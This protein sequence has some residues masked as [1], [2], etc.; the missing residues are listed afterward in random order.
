MRK[1]LQGKLKSLTE[2]VT[3]L[4]SFLIN[5]ILYRKLPASDVKKI[6]I[7]K[8]DHIG[9]V[10]L[11]TPVI[12]NL[13]LRYPGA[14]I[15]MLVGSWSKSIIESN[16][17]LDE[18]FC[19]D[20]PFFCRN[21]K[22]TSFKGAVKLFRRLRTEQFDLLV[23]L[24]GNFLTLILAALKCS[25]YRLDRAT[26]RIEGKL[27]GFALSEH[28]VEIN[29][30][31]LRYADIPIKSHI[32]FFHVSQKLQIWG[33]KFLKE[34][35]IQKFRPI[36]AI[37]PTSPV[38]IKRWPSER[39]AQL[40]DTLMKKFDAQILFLGLASE[41]EIIAEIQSLMKSKSFNI[42]GQTNLRQLSGVL[43]H[44]QLHIGN[45]SGPMHLAATVG[46]P[47]I[48]LF[49]PGSPQRFGPRGSNCIAI[50][51]T[52]CPPCMEASCRL[53]GRGCITEITVENVINLLSATT[54]SE[55]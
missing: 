6:L 10:L 41:K 8:L 53:G 3:L 35:G 29:L 24:R 42:A 27:F 18:M 16:P 20:A 1:G 55:A 39:F 5:N 54:L 52:D 33:K 17:Y 49:G 14:H 15:A 37:H 32:P 4:S 46:T 47:V 21:G 19:Y 12:T 9:D 44:C 38:L 51:K 23:E 28:E 13:R 45:D 7:V 25:K 48:G 26:Q 11:A 22:P 2:Y 30:D 40:S 50:R 31:V 43:Q 36:I 34:I